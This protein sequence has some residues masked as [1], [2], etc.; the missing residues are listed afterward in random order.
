[1][2]V[3]ND[4]EIFTIKELKNIS[5]KK[6]RSIKGVGSTTVSETLSILEKQGITLQEEK[7]S[8]V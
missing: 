2:N 1:L 5:V 8:Y 3:L 6:L 4:L 7:E